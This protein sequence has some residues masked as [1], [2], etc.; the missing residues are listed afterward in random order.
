MS[1][2]WN[3]RQTLWNSTTIGY[4]RKIAFERLFT[5]TLH[6]TH[7]EFIY[8]V[9]FHFPR[10]LSRVILKV[11]TS[12]PTLIEFHPRRPFYP[13]S[14]TP[15]RFFF[16]LF[17]LTATHHHLVSSNIVAVVIRRSWGAVTKDNY[18]NIRAIKL[19]R[20]SFTPA[21]VITKEATKRSAMASEAKK[22]LPIRRRLRSV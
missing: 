15:W 4:D 11:L 20:R 17:F 2:A 7:F 22:R 8:K 5:R 12:C 19:P 18:D 3:L 10:C 6:S 16:L 21:N 1:T 14:R 13:P 9:G